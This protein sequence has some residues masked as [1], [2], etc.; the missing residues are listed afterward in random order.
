MPQ[1]KL[2]YEDEFESLRLMISHSE[3]ETKEVA[4]FLFPDR[5]PA[6]AYARLQACLNPEKDERLTFGQIIAAMIF[7]DRFDPLYY[8]CEETMHGRP[9]VRSRV[10]EEANIFTVISNAATVM[11]RALKKLDHMKPRKSR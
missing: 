10:D 5:K 6:S 8:A 3:K 9:P 7:C 11:E 4:C 1:E 2:F